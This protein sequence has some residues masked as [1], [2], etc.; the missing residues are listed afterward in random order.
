[1]QSKYLIK[2]EY[3]EYIKNSYHSTTKNNLLLK[4][5]KGLNRHFY[6]EGI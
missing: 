2:G 4:W 3:P 1:M 5:A 6:K